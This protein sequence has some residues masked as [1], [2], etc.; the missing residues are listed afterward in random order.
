MNSPT[1]T[2]LD[3]AEFAHWPDAIHQQARALLIA[4]SALIQHG[5]V[6]LPPRA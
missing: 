4:A 2:V 1:Y 3:L 6:P 5:M